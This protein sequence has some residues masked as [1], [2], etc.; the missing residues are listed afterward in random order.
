MKKKIVSVLIALTMV[1]GTAGS[2]LPLLSELPSVIPVSAEEYQGFVYE[3]LG[4]AIMIRGYNGTAAELTIPAEI[5][6]T[7][8]MGIG[9]EAFANNKSLTKVTLSEGITNIGD[10]AFKGCT[11]L[12]T[13][14][15]PDGLQSVGMWAFMSCISLTEITLPDSLWS[16]GRYAFDSCTSLTSINVP[17]RVWDVCPDSFDRCRSL[18][19]INVAPDNAN[20]RTVNGMLFSK[21]GTELLKA[22]CGLASAAVP[23]GTVSI[24]AEAFNDSPKLSSVTLPEGLKNIGK[25][26]FHD[27]P[28]LKELTVPESVET[29]GPKAVGFYYNSETHAITPVEDLVIYCWYESAAHKYAVDNDIDYVLLDTDQ[30]KGRI[31][32]RYDKPFDLTETGFRITDAG[33]QEVNAPVQIEADGKFAIR[34]LPDGEYTLTVSL[35]GFP[36][37]AEKFTVL[38]GCITSPDFLLYHYGDVNSDGSVNMKDLTLLQRYINNWNVDIN[39]AA[40]N[41]RRDSSIN[42]KDLTSL[43]RFINGW[44]KY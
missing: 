16:L 4:G 13:A 12:K 24:A 6:G 33:G 15:L 34:S 42:M 10:D 21:D 28:S 38:T 43:Q 29:I 14:V 39:E 35:E 2:E 11:A 37:A 22:P 32:V 23:E 30:I 27:C 1:L 41:I 8:V 9:Y 17:A 3:D 7:P 36:P 44:E 26:A 20:C 40:A 31:T 5:D 25:Y 18:T 19:S